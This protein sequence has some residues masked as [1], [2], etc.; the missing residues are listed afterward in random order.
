MVETIVPVVHGT[1]S[2][3]ISLGLF[4]AGAIGTAALLGL[5]LGGRAAARGLRRGGGR[6]RARAGGGGR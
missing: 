5:A 3:L 6:G 2:W 4:T 1:R